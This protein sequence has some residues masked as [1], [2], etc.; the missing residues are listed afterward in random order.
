MRNMGSVCFDGESL[1]MHGHNDVHEIFISN[2][3]DKT[4]AGAATV[5]G[6]HWGY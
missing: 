2:G 5:P 1:N 6:P 3:T 4:W